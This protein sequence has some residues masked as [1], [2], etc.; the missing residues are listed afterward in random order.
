MAN[1]AIISHL[2]RLWPVYE[3][4][5]AHFGLNLSASFDLQAGT[6]AEALSLLM[7]W[8]WGNVERIHVWLQNSATLELAN[9][10][11]FTVGSGEFDGEPIKNA[12][13]AE[14]NDIWAN[15]AEGSESFVWRPTVG[16]EEEQESRRYFRNL[17]GYVS[18]LPA[19]APQQL[20]LSL[21]FKLPASMLVENDLI[22]AVPE[23]KG[24]TLGDIVPKA[25]GPG[26]TISRSGV[27]IHTWN[28]EPGA[29]NVQAYTVPWKVALTPESS[30]TSYI[31]F[32]SYWIKNSFKSGQGEWFGTDWTVRLES[33]IAGAFDLAQRLIDTFRKN[34]DTIKDPAKFDD[35]AYTY[36][37]SFFRQAV[38]ASVRDLAGTGVQPG[39]DGADVAGYLLS[40]SRD[41]ALETSGLMESLRLSMRGALE[42]Y[43]R[44][45]TYEEWR[46]QVESIMAVKATAAIRQPAEFRR[47]DRL[48]D[49]LGELETIQSALADENNLRN[50][51]LAQWNL[52]ANKTGS[53]TKTT[54]T[55]SQANYFQSIRPGKGDTGLLSLNDG[56]TWVLTLA[57][58]NSA[59]LASGDK[60]FFRVT[61]PK[62]SPASQIA[63]AAKAMPAS[64]Q[65][66][67]SGA[68]K[69]MASAATAIPSASTR[70]ALR[71]R[72]QHSSIWSLAA[73]SSGVR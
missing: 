7:P 52:A 18:T 11:T 10:V 57:N 53:I 63:T 20:N 1:V 45:Q 55:S 13:L 36:L 72:E 70:R 64:F 40:N 3:A 12:I 6:Q 24:G 59:G 31:D 71:A 48:D 47:R 51:L 68:K 14:A 25:T 38:V 8:L 23:F 33:K 56:R 4:N 15:P 61:D 69:P 32:G 19:P 39:A 67:A 22:F 66:S 21:C 43:N 58:L 30:D 16:V 49:E 46:K 27:T 35:Q 5:Q 26:S 44:T 41:V 17:L 62:L 2:E 9:V 65:P 34:T 29:H 42:F 37:L 50:L 60:Y 54:V 28:Y 73:R